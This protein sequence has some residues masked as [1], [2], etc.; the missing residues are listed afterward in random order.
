M[1]I[2]PRSVD[3]SDDVVDDSPFDIREAKVASRV[4]IGQFFMI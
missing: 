4:P 1:R 2:L 3:S